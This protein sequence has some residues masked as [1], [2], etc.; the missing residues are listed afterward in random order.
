MSN[1][2]PSQYPAVVF[3]STHQHLRAMLAIAIAFNLGLPIAVVV[4]ATRGNSSTPGTLASP[5]TQSAIPA[6][7]SAENGAK[8]DHSGRN[9]TVT[10]TTDRLAHYPDTPPASASSPQ[11]SIGYYLNSPQQ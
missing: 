2:V 11:P 10:Q 9:A 7:A 5:A 1:T 3:R 8:L 6:H 4:F